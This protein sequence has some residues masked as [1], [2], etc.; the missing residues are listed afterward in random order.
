MHFKFVRVNR[1]WKYAP[2]S[3]KIII[4]T[5]KVSDWHKL[6]FEVCVPSIGGI[7]VPKMKNL[8]DKL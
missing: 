7:C 1:F 6:N 8:G 2:I 4:I 3:K 5:Q